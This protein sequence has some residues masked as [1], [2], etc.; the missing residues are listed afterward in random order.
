MGMKRRHSLGKG[1]YAS[2]CIEDN[3]PC[4]SHGPKL[5]LERKNG[6]TP[7]YTCSAFRNQPACRNDTEFTLKLL[8]TQI[9]VTDISKSDFKNACFCHTCGVFFIGPTNVHADHNIVR[10]LSNS[11][12]NAPSYFLEPLEKSSEHAQ[13]FFADEW[14]KFMMS[15]LRALRIDNI[16]CVGAPRLFDFL[17]T[18]S[19]SINKFLLDLDARLLSFYPPTQFTRFN[20]LNC[21]FF[22]PTGKSTVE[23]FMLSCKG[24]TAIFCDPPFGALM[25]PLIVS[26]NKLKEGIL[27]S[28]VFLMITI[29]YFLGKK[30]LQAAPQLK[31]LDYKV[32][33]EKHVRFTSTGHDGNNS[34][35][36]V[37][38][39]R[40]FTDAPP[41][42]IKPP[43]G[44]ESQ[45]WFCEICKRYSD[46]GN[47][48]CTQCNACTT[49]HGGT[50]IHCQICKVCR[51]PSYQHCN[52]CKRCFHLRGNEYHSCTNEQSTY[53]SKCK[54][55][56]FIK[57]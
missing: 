26:L 56:K 48:H 23:N 14:L 4:C 8:R 15:T 1:L 5:R 2:F 12:L 45:Y 34:K 7:S 16:L 42:E 10:D 47:K 32:T 30:L 20:A 51:P 37:S 40:M 52:K 11:K 53:H 29:P 36:R 6:G 49:P 13:Y 35:R 21:H 3:A 43:E 27:N 31:M 54:R 44:L 19:F 38:V 28:E 50:Y 33:Y 39:V 25:E 24:R 57:K 22:S 46:L 55:G 17:G 18:Q 41:Q 9:F